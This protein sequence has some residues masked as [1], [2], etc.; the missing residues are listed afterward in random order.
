MILLNTNLQIIKTILNADGSHNYIMQLS[1]C[2][3]D[4]LFNYY[5]GSA[6]NKIIIIKEKHKIEM[7]YS[8]FMDAYSFTTNT[9]A[10]FKYEF[11]TESDDIYLKCGI[12]K[13]QLKYLYQKDFNKISNLILKMEL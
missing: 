8:L 10:S 5:T 1:Y 2:N 13:K 7:L 11:A 3:R 12:I 6:H 4:F 9:K